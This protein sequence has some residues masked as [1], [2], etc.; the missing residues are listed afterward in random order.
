MNLN[1]RTLLYAASVTAAGA[2]I[3]VLVWLYAGGPVSEP[4]PDVA[5]R[6]TRPIADTALST[7]PAL[8][9]R[10]VPAAAPTRTNG[11][12]A[13][14]GAKNALRIPIQQVA[15][16]VNGK[17]IPARQLFMGRNIRRQDG[18]FVMDEADYRRRVKE[19]VDRRLVMDEV[20]R[21]GLRM[22][23]AERKQ[24]TDLRRK[25]MDDMR[26]PPVD[27]G[28]EPPDIV[29]VP[30]FGGPREFRAVLMDETTRIME[31]KLLADAGVRSPFV[32]DDDVSA[33]YEKNR[34][35]FEAEPV[36]PDEAA[37][38]WERVQ[39][40]IRDEL[41]PTVRTQSAAEREAYL[42]TLRDA[43]TIEFPP[44]EDEAATDT[45]SPATP[46]QDG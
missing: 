42:Q 4:V 21:R 40:T 11:V 3:A 45:E 25:L 19:A 41:A 35:A 14:R 39:A 30:V 44:V 2:L 12:P 23:P 8:P 26:T 20:R 37:A 7:V 46:T 13:A 31:K 15:A 32:Q 1:A 10:D 27:W 6:D 43:A 33:Y 36:D 22:E 17:P 16:I 18:H 9:P 29:P 24:L 38:H 34:N 5:Y 28:G